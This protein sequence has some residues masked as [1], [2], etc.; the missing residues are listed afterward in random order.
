MV[1]NRGQDLRDIGIQWCQYVLQED[2]LQLRN[3]T[4]E[5]Q[6]FQKVGNAKG[7]LAGVAL[8]EKTVLLLQPTGH[9]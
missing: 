3:D 1:S 2:P 9:C 7:N 8:R 6:T 5:F 4:K